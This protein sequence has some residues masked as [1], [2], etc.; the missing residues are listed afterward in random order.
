MCRHNAS[1][2]VV[3]AGPTRGG[4]SVKKAR[5]REAGLWALDTPSYFSC[6]QHAAGL[7]ETGSFAL[8]A[9]EGPT[10]DSN[11]SRGGGGGDVCGRVS[12]TARSARGMRPPVRSRREVYA[13]YF[14]QSPA[15]NRRLMA[16]TAKCSTTID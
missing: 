5:F 14:R 13:P 11:S 1:P 6:F 8:P 10:S 12:G 15:S 7:A 2:F 9:S 16:E 4:D 3:R